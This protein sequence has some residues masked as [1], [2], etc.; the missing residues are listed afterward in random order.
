MKKVVKGVGERLRKLRTEFL[1]M[2]QKELAQVL[3]VKQNTI[4]QWEKEE[5]D[6]P[7]AVYETLAT[8]FNVNINWL[9]T[10]SGEPF[11]TPSAEPVKKKTLTKV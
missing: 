11:L 5:R 9:L 2:T 6:I 10:G 8:E 4:S 1:G 7:T 3:G